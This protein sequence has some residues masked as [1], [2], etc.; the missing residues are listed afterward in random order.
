L[1]I[2]FLVLEEIIRND[3][4]LFKK[5]E[6]YVEKECCVVTNLEINYTKAEL[7][8]FEIRDQVGIIF[9]NNGFIYKLNKEFKNIFNK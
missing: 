7:D 1:S 4:K 8:A 3:K 6:E 5:I 2:S 9:L